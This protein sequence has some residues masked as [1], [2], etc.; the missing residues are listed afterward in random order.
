MDQCEAPRW[1][2]PHASYSRAN[3]WR[4][5]SQ[6]SPRWN[7]IKKQSAGLTDGVPKKQLRSQ[8]AHHLVSA[9]AGRSAAV[10]VR[11]SSHDGLLSAE[12]IGLQSQYRRDGA[13]ARPALLFLISGDLCLQL[14][15]SIFGGT[16]LIR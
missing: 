2:E 9:T 6:K 16:Q 5:Q 13:T 4:S 12:K 8:G 7:S 1:C 14:L 11:R 15:N 3:E 10:A